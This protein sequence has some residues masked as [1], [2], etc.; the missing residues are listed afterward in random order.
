M[1][2]TATPH[3]LHSAQEPVKSPADRSSIEIGPSK[4]AVEFVRMFART[5]VALPASTPSMRCI[6]AN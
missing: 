3:S 6:V 4:A 5:C 2:K 1:H